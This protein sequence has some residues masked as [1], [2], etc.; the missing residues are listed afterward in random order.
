MNILSLIPNK[1][2][3]KNKYRKFKKSD[4]CLQHVF[5]HT[6]TSQTR[7]WAER[8]DREESQQTPLLWQ[9]ALSRRNTQFFSWYRERT[10]HEKPKMNITASLPFPTHA[11]TR[12]DT[13]STKWQRGLV[14][15]LYL[16][17]SNITLCFL[18]L[19]TLCKANLPM[20]SSHIM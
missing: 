8:R 6:H 2:E 11:H 13:P 14:Y 5:T 3:I 12:R 7:K 1:N 4:V 15:T 19:I 17:S 9:L 20:D 10:C 18:C 16:Y